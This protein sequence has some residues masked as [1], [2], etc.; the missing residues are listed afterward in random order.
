MIYSYDTSNFYSL[1]ENNTS[2]QSKAHFTV[3]DYKSALVKKSYK[4]PSG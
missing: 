1:Q 4:F 3:N 2:K